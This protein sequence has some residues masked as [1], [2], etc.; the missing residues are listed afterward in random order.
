MADSVSEIASGIYRIST[1]AP[2]FGIQ[3]NQFLIADDEPMLFHTGLRTM[4]EAT[5]TGVAEVLDPT[6]LRWL[7][8]SHFE[9]DESGAL[10]DWLTLAPRA[11]AVCS[12]VGKI[13]CLDDFAD[14]PARALADGEVLPLGRHR[15]RFLATPHV[16]HG[17]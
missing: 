6:S 10:N 13:V 9:P 2:S 8:Y 1:F 3:F 7:G 5:R 12:V 14:R 16:P 4:F 17:W 15:M 11:Q